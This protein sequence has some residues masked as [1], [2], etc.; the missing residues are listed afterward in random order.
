M[1]KYLIHKNLI[2]KIILSIIVVYSA[3]IFATKTHQFFI[4][5]HQIERKN[6]PAVI[7]LLGF[8]KTYQEDDDIGWTLY[9]YDLTWYYPHEGSLA[10]QFK[11]EPLTTVTVGLS[12]RRSND[13]RAHVFLYGRGNLYGYCDTSS[14][15]PIALYWNINLHNQW[16]F[17]GSDAMA[18]VAFEN[19]NQW[20]QLS[21]APPG[22]LFLPSWLKGDHWTDVHN[23]LIL[24]A[25]PK[26][27]VYLKTH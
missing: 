2:L 10:D 11:P 12:K 4:L 8:M 5:R 9:I 25:K 26:K 22:T 21:K 16:S 15:L 19:E 1:S 24:Q 17:E 7:P 13:I 23:K 6:R 18:I 27:I 3:F 20:N 14:P